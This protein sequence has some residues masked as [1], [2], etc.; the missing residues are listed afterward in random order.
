[1]WKC[2]V[3]DTSNGAA[4]CAQCGFDRSCDYETYPTLEAIPSG[5]SSRAGRKAQLIQPCGLQLEWSL[6]ERGVLEITGSGKMYDYRLLKNGA[7]TDAPW[8]SRRKEIKKVEISDG[9]TGIGEAAFANCRDLM[10]IVIPES[11]ER[12]G[13]SAFKNCQSLREA[14]LPSGITHIDCMVFEGCKSLRK[15]SI[16]TGISE[17]KAFALSGCIGFSEFSIPA[18]VTKIGDYAFYGCSGL[19]EIVLP[20]GITEVGRMAFYGCE[21][22]NTLWVMNPETKIDGGTSALGNA[23]RT[24]LR[25]HR[26]STAE[27]YAQRQGYQFEPLT[28]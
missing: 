14:M 11:V 18:G 12:I 19:K 6:S 15:I 13:P 10:E 4:V 1:M 28:G 23:S 26:G 17:I 16:P 22:L 2:P 5:C 9:V 20:E 8:F 7:A 24:K 27:R 3:C 21:S 25:G